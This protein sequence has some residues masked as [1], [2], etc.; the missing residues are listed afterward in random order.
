[1]PASRMSAGTA[2]SSWQIAMHEV[3]PP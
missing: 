3:C 2:A 1:V